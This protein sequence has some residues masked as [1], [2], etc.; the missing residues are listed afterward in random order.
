MTQ[1][2]QK[3]SPQYYEMGKKFLGAFVLA[4]AATASVGCQGL[5]TALHNIGQSS[6]QNLERGWYNIT[7]SDTVCQRRVS[8]TGT[9]NAGSGDTSRNDLG[10]VSQ[11]CIE[12]QKMTAYELENRKLELMRAETQAKVMETQAQTQARIREAEMARQHELN[13]RADCQNAERQALQQNRDLPADHV[14]YT[15][16]YLTREANGATKPPVGN[17]GVEVKKGAVSKN[18]VPKKPTDP[19]ASG[20]RKFADFMNASE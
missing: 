18:S 7:G 11:D 20:W 15:K 5:G 3:G 12:P 13:K 17:G 8:S 14:C 1:L 4:A 10:R 2:I 19:N 6:S 9:R 16:G